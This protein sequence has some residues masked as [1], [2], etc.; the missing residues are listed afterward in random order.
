M[1]AMTDQ[2]R[3]TDDALPNFESAPCAFYYYN[4]QEY[5]GSQVEL[6]KIKYNTVW[7]PLHYHAPGSKALKY[8][9]L[10]IHPQWHR[11]SGAKKYLVSHQ[12]CKFSHLKR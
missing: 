9:V 4:F 12:L 6:Q 1:Y 3:G 11:Y 7:E 10:P 8:F 5:Y 2:T